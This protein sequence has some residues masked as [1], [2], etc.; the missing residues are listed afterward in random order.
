M[1]TE[2]VAALVKANVAD[3]AVVIVVLL[4]R[5]PL[6]RM[7]GQSLPYALWPIVPIAGA[8]SLLPV[9]TVVAELPEAPFLGVMPA[10]VQL[11]AKADAAQNPEP[12]M[13]VTAVWILGAVV[14]VIVCAV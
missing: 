8:A 10:T 1:I 4:V 9:R 2:L 13:A 7:A 12:A 11:L 5:R 6:G 14:G 3:A